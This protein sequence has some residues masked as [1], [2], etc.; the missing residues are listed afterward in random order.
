MNRNKQS[1]SGSQYKAR[2]SNKNRGPVVKKDVVFNY[3]ELYNDTDTLKNFVME[4]GRMV[5]SRIT[6]VTAK[7]QR[8]ITH[9]I[10]LARFLSL[11]KYC[12]S[13]K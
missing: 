11:I 4:S 7:Q 12:D 8:Q 9:A 5:P 2:R 13:H 3:A 1:N 6:G 10:K